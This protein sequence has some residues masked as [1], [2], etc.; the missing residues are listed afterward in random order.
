MKHLEQH[1]VHNECLLYVGG[2]GIAGD[3]CKDQIYSQRVSGLASRSS[4][5]LHLVGGCYVEKTASWRLILILK[6][7]AGK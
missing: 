6:A 3:Y 1:L 7:F 5:Y 4:C 2:G